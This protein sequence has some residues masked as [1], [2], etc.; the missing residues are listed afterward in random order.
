MKKNA[1]LFI[2]SAFFT[3]RVALFI[4]LAF[5][6]KYLPIQHDFLGGGIS[7]Y[8][9]NPY[10]WSWFNFDGEHYLS[11]IREGYKPLTYFFFPGFP[12]LIKYLA[13]IFATD[14]ISYALFG[15]VISNVIF[16]LALVGLW[17]LILLD[18]D[19]KIAK[20][21]IILML[22]FPTS[23]YF[24]SFYTEA[25]FLASVVW[26]MYFA[27]KDR[28]VLSGILGGFSSLTRVIGVAITPSLLLENLNFKKGFKKIISRKGLVYIILAPLGLVLYMYYLWKVTGDPLNFLNNVEIFGAQRSSTFVV[29]PQVF[30]RYVFKIIPNL[31]FEYFPSLFSTLMEFSTAVLFLFISIFSFYKL[32][33][34]YSLFVLLGYLI[35]TLS[36]S[37]SSVP[38]YVAILFPGFIFLSLWLQDRSIF[39]RIAFYS[40]SAVCLVISTLMFVRGYWIS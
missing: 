38:R 4:I 6:I 26:S 11:L 15:L 23:F 13:G 16:I 40:L 24:G 34:S 17:K 20:L 32:R 21:S 22:I 18:Y 39:V 10:L 1:L 35:P 28:W 5:G 2:L 8:T 31:N 30:Y 37:F 27:R 7:E 14:M 29:L 36:G 3:W 9:K 19:E 12:F 33:A 25:T